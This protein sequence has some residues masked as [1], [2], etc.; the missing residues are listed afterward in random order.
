[1]LSNYSVHSLDHDYSAVLKGYAKSNAPDVQIWSLRRA[2]PGPADLHYAIS[3]LLRP[4]DS[5]T[6]LSL[7]T[8]KHNQPC[9]LSNYKPIGKLAPSRAE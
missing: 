8:A 6:T 3:L 7:K 9:L 5:Y 2:F 4:T 1:M